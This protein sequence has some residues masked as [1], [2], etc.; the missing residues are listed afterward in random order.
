MTAPIAK[1][2]RTL[3]S[4]A[5]LVAAGLVAPE[6]AE[7]LGA[8]AA[9]YAV[10]VPPTIAALIDPT[11]PADPLARSYLPDAAERVTTAAER[12]DPIGDGAHAPVAGIVHRYP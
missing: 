12:A 5:D 9:R 2:P 4:V 10:A 1:R 11:D 7:A 6:R 3:T 8:V